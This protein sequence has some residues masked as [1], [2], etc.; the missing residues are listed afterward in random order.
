MLTPSNALWV[1]PLI[2]AGG[3]DDDADGVLTALGF[4]EVV[5]Q[6][7]E[8]VVGVAQEP[9]VD[10]CHPGEQALLVCRQRAPRLGE[11][12]VG[13]R[14]SVRTGPGVGSADRVDRW[15]VRLPCDN[16]ELLLTLHDL[17][18]DR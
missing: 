6:P 3:R 10:L 13:E 18:A 14:L 16:A 7:A 2:V 12:Q 9:G 1:C 8:L 4:V 11:V 5:Q 17:L 15:Q